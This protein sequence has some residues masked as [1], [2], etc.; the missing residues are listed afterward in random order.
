MSTCGHIQSVDMLTEAC[1]S[2]HHC[3]TLVIIIV[4]YGEETLAGVICHLNHVLVEV[5][6]TFKY[7]YIQHDS[8]ETYIILTTLITIYCT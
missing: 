3:V 6:L 8:T 2:E 1:Y 5:M 7:I 4:M